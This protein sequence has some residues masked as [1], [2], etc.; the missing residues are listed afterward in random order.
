VFRYRDIAW[1]LVNREPGKNVNVLM[2]GGYPAFIRPSQKEEWE[3]GVLKVLHEEVNDKPFQ[4]EYPDSWRC[5]RDDDL[6]L[7][8]QWSEEHADSAVVRTQTALNA[9]DVGNTD[10]LFGLFGEYH[11]PYDDE[12]KDGQDPSLSEMVGKA[13][14]ACKVFFFKLYSPDA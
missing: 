13:I 8:T 2:G 10:Y 1:Q 5:E 7:I 3:R 14:Q 12:R 11:M 9:V 6:D 4:F